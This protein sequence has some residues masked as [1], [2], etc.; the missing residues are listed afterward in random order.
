MC[1][2]KKLRMYIHIYLYMYMIYKYIQ[3]NNCLHNRKHH[4]FS[5]DYY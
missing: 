4:T 1:V 5:T 3:I 2:Y